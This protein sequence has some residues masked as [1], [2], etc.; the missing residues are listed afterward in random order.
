V[1]INSGTNASASYKIL[2]KIAPV[3]SEFERAKIENCAVAG[4]QFD[5]RRSF[6][7]LA[8]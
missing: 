3:T 6:G 1:W 7:T 4:L 5:D 2:V 8:F